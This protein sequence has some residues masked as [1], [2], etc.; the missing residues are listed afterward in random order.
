[1]QMACDLVV[2]ISK[3]NPGNSIVI[4]P[5]G[6]A[7]T[8]WDR[9]WTGGL[10]GKYIK[11]QTKARV[12]KQMADTFDTCGEMSSLAY[13]VLHMCHRENYISEIVLAVRS[14]QA[15]RAEF[16]CRRQL[17]KLNLH[18][19][20]VSTRTYELSLGRGKSAQEYI[21]ARPKT[22]LGYLL[23]WV[24][25]TLSFCALARASGKVRKSGSPTTFQDTATRSTS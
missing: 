23:T 19:I 18:H 24:N 2:S 25:V 1:M 9:V 13:T 8:E 14:R 16:L 20:S 11:A 21:G 6:C 10:M 12:L 22:F 7:G 17:N 15:P 5:G 3:E 4:T